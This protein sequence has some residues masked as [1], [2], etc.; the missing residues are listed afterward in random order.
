VPHWTL[1]DNFF[2]YKLLVLKEVVG[3]SCRF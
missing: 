1:R 3:H 2:A